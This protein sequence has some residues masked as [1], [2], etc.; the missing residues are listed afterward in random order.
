[1]GTSHKNENAAGVGK[2]R[3]R[4]LESVLVVFSIIISL[5]CY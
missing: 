2:L 3:E 5:L 1:M 4:A